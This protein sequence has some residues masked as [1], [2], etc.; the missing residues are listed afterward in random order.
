MLAGP[1]PP[2]FLETYSLSTSSLG[3]NA[4]CIVISFLVL[5]SIC[6]SSSMVHLRKGPEYL[7]RGT[8]QVFIPL[9]SVLLLSFVSSSFLVLLRYSFWIFSFISAC[10]MVLASKMPNYLLASFSASV[11]I[12]SSFGSSI[13][14][15]LFQYSLQVFYNCYSVNFSYLV[16][17]WSL[18][19]MKSSQIFCTLLRIRA[20]FNCAVI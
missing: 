11:F 4:L 10:L 12:L 1:L 17:D 20:D 3:Y 15:L 6:L 19:D 5:W 9:I 14:S 7:T 18:S 2:S 16:F 13:P 8:A